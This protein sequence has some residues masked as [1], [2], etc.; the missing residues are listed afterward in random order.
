MTRFDFDPRTPR[1]RSNQVQHEAADQR[2]L[3]YWMWANRGKHKAL[4]LAYAIP[5]G[6]LRN[7]AVAGKLKAEGVKSG[8]PDIC[9]PW[10][11]HG[12]QWP[13][14]QGY[15]ALYIELKHGDNKP[16]EEQ[17]WWMTELNAAG[18][19]AVVC[20]GWESAARMVCKYLGVE[21]TI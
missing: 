16:T 18:N 10:P 2:A 20:Y 14:G 13:H 9:L 5:N 4:S 7:K 1:K 17:K 15:G 8:V 6:G 21:I 11:M 3:F 19:L 12:S